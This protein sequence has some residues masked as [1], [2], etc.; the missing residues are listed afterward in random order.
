MLWVS[1]YGKDRKGDVYEILKWL[2]GAS[3]DLVVYI[4]RDMLDEKTRDEVFKGL[5]L[6]YKSLGIRMANSLSDDYQNLWVRGQVPEP[7]SSARIFLPHPSSPARRG[8]TT[9]PKSSPSQKVRT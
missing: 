7:S 5:L 8:S 2:K 9:P 4:D 3:L 6:E 1:M